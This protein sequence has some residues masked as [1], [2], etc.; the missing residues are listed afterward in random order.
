M[1][2]KII[3][4]DKSLFDWL[5]SDA[6]KAVLTVLGAVLGGIGVKYYDYRMSKNKVDQDDNVLFVKELRDELKEYRTMIKEKDKELNELREKFY[7]LLVQSGK[8]EE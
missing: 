8:S 2:D 5:N 1:I 7:N 3:G 4:S 6:I